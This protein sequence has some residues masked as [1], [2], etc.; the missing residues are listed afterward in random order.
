MTVVS[1]GK[2]TSTEDDG[3]EGVELV[4]S[5]FIAIVGCNVVVDCVVDVG[6]AAISGFCPN[7]KRAAP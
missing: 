1:I 3:I 2:L 5:T 7:V 6:G 4:G